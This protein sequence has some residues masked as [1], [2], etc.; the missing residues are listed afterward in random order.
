ME[1]FIIFYERKEI[2]ILKHLRKRE[3]SPT[4]LAWE[5]KNPTNYLYCSSE[6]VEKVREMVERNEKSGSINNV[7]K[8][9]DGASRG[10]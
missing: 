4:E 3:P 7:Q 6:A 1:A 2:K 5:E 10:K 9:K 8:R